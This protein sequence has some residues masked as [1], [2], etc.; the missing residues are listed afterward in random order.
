M[1]SGQEIALRSETR[2]ELEAVVAGAAVSYSVQQGSNEFAEELFTACP[3]STPF[4]NVQ[5]REIYQAA[6]RIAER[7]EQID[8]PALG[9]EMERHKAT[10]R[11]A[12]LVSIVSNNWHT[13]PGA[14]AAA[15]KIVEQ[16]QRAAAAQKLESAKELLNLDSPP[17]VALQ[18]INEALATLGDIE[19]IAGELE[20]PFIS[21]EDLFKLPPTK[22]IVKGLFSR[23]DLCVLTAS[24]GQGKSFL[25]LDM[26]IRIS[27]GWSWFGMKTTASPLVYVNLETIHETAQRDDRLESWNK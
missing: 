26:G 15:R 27:R 25:A 24:Y 13:R 21:S 8:V 11:G 20:N 12:E 2:A 4:L 7:G 14:L 6:A 19:S 10:C 3:P 23:G 18:Y 22:P 17:D 1:G 16:E 5:A 9:L